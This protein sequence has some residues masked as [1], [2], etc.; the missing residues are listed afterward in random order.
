MTYHR[1][2][3]KVAGGSRRGGRWLLSV[4]LAACLAMFL[5]ACASS[6]TSTGSQAT[7]A[8]ASDA[9]CLTQPAAPAP[10]DSAGA[11]SALPAALAADYGGYDAQVLPSPYKDFKTKLKAPWTVGFSNN[12]P[13]DSWTSVAASEL[14]SLASQNKQLVKSVISDQAQGDVTTQIQQI[15]SMIQR[16]AGIIVLISQSPTALNAVIKQAFDAGVVVVTVTHPVTSPYAINL[17]VNLYQAGQIM[18]LGLAKL[19][20]GSGNVLMVEGIQGSLSSE[21]LE[22]GAQQVFNRCPN[23]HIVANVY[24]Q[25]SESEAKVAV[26]QTLATHPGTINAVWQQGSMFMG[27]VQAF[28]QSG[29]T[30]PPVSDGDPDDDALAYWHDNLSKGYN[31]VA[32]ANPP[33]ADMDAAFRIAAYTALGD[34]PKV[35]TVITP[36]PTITSANL[37]EWWKSSYTQASTGVAEPPASSPMWLP[38]STLKSY[39]TTFTSLP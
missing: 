29:R 25:W 37:N 24:G 31:M 27:I 2:Q 20:N 3:V 5:A 18:A 17:N 35:S 8:G 1:R 23:I 28:Q 19:L 22:S 6:G 30:V 15:Q 34:G 4:L 33:Q 11:L 38:D 36:E 21:Q 32:T 26:L 10:P 39:F 7:A 12:S 14:N 16:G 13:P 9:A